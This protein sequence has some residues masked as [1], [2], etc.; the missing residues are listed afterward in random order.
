MKSFPGF[1]IQ[2]SNPLIFPIQ[3]NAFRW[4][5][6]LPLEMPQRRLTM[7]H[8]LL[9]LVGFPKPM[10]F[11]ITSL[12]NLL[13]RLVVLS[14]FST[15]CASNLAMLSLGLLLIEIPAQSVES[16][17]TIPPLANLNQGSRFAPSHLDHRFRPF[18]GPETTQLPCN[19]DI[20]RLKKFLVQMVTPF[21]RIF[22]LVALF[23]TSLN[24][25]NLDQMI[26]PF[27][28]HLMVLNYIKIRSRIHGSPSGLSM[29]MIRQHDTRKNTFYLLWSFLDPT[30][31]RISILSSFVACTTSLLS[32]VK[33]MAEECMYG[34]DFR[35]KWYNHMSYSCLQQQMQ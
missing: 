5:C 18:V 24:K 21:T 20:R 33:T 2:Y 30:N 13:P 27:R 35:R 29:T 11:H 6:L 1:E 4:T 31:R 15:I 17:D 9:S 19:T 22:F 34:M 12:K 7:Q 32:N 16:L 3:M 23:S 26:L 8:A 10:C 25:S 14:W 28:F